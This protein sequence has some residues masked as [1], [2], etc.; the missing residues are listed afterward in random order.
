MNQIVEMIFSPTGGTR[1][2]ADK[3]GGCLGEVKDVVGLTRYGVDFSDVEIENEDLVVIAAPVFE[4]VIPDLAIE[5]LKQVKG[6]GANCVVVAV[7]GNRAYDDGLI[8]LKDTA[9]LCNFK[10]IAS[11]AAVAEHSIMRQFG[12]GRPDA[13]DEKELQEFADKILAKLSENNG[14]STD[15]FVPGNHEYKRLGNLSVVPKANRKCTKCGKCADA[16]PTGAIDMND[17]KTADSDRC[18]SCMGC[19]AACPVG[20]R[21]LNSL[22]LTAASMKMKDLLSG[23][24]PNEIFL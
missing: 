6:N 4:G 2:V 19:I 21:K 9:E 10:V 1:K 22:F 23:R 5:R 17:I 16:C 18:I 8:E 13:D 11:I 7:Y 15:Y 12:A 3:L 24:K 20:A 14:I